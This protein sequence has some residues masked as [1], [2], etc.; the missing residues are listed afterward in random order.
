MENLRNRTKVKFIK[1]DDIDKILKK[2][3]LTF[4]GFRKS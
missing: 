3:K 4:T 1:K 2:F